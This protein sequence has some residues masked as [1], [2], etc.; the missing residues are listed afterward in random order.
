MRKAAQFGVNVNQEGAK[1]A[2]AVNVNDDEETLTLLVDGTRFVVR[3]SMFT[4]HPDTMLGRM[5]SSRGHFDIRPNSRG[6]FEVG[7]G[8]HDVA[9]SA[10][11]F[12]T[13]LDFYRCGTISCPSHLP[14]AELRE[15]CDYFL[16]P[17]TSATVK[18]QNLRG[19]LH[20]LSNDGAEDKFEDFLDE[21]ILPEMVIAASRGDRECHIVILVD[22]D[23]IDWDEDFPPPQMGSEENTQTIV[24]T[25]LYR[26]FRYV[27]NREVA[28]QVLRERGL[29]KVKLGIEGHPT[30][31]EKVKKRFDG[32]ADV[33]YNYV[34]RP[35]IHMSWEKEEAKS[36]HVDFQCVKSKSVTNLAEA[37][38]D[39]TIDNFDGRGNPINPPP[40]AALP[41]AQAQN[42]A[43]AAPAAIVP[44]LQNIANPAANAPAPIVQGAGAVN[45]IDPAVAVPDPEL[46]ARRR[47]RG[48]SHDEGVL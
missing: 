40:A 46:D 4:R 41:N 13:I 34:Q 38:A 14:V 17:F 42:V 43:G 31:K 9:I 33:I 21:L 20:E 27:E 18:C 2:H 5:F 10:T 12:D 3:P 19:L 37:A 28:K 44:A 16:I 11:A 22:E 36:R 15:A 48:G 25:P 29:K 8:G 39:P 35:F 23:Q 1:A 24:S 32:K 6:E 7:N 26:F 30:H 47:L 45:V